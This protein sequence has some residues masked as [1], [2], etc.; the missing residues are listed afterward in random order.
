MAR[1]ELAVMPHVQQP[2]ISTQ[3]KVYLAGL[4]PQI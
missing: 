2:D 4:K 3:T 1:D